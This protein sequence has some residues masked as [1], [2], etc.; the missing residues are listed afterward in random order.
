MRPAGPGI[1]F[2]FNSED[3]GLVANHSAPQDGPAGHVKGWICSI[4]TLE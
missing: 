1:Q 2:A 4:A 3:K